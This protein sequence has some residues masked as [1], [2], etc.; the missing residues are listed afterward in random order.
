MHTLAV[1]SRSRLFETE[2]KLFVFET[3]YYAFCGRYCFE[4]VVFAKVNVNTVKQYLLHHILIDNALI[5]IAKLGEVTNDNEA[6][7]RVRSNDNKPCLVGER[8]CIEF[9]DSK[10]KTWIKAIFLTESYELKLHVV[11]CDAHVHY[12]HIHSTIP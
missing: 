12:I 10:K 11:S 8:Y 7:A 3:S 6:I 4:C 1:A 2:P 5:R 9:V